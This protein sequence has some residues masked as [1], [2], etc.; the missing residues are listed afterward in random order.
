ML[1]PGINGL[2]P[3]VYIIN[4]ASEVLDYGIPLD[5]AKLW[6]VTAI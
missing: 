5:A 2:R 1:N 4:I 6:Y 3:T